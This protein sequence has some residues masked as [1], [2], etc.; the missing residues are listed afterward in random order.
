M[1]NE[2]A[3]LAELKTFLRMNETTNDT[4]LQDKLTAASRRVDRD[5]GRRF[6]VDGSATARTYRA[7]HATLLM[8]DDISTTNSLVV[9]VG[10]GSS[11]TTVDSTLFDTLPENALA[12]GWAIET[13]DRASGCWPLFGSTRVRVTAKWGWP[14]VPDPIKAACLLLAGRL[15][16]RKDSPEGVKGF[17][18]MGVVRV[19]R[20]DSDYDNAIGPYVRTVT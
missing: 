8:V 2:Y 9:E 20:Y 16:R 7:T 14:A 1:A 4:E 10:R 3:S 5:T 15:F 11:W 19:S 12:D 18:D 17:S 6:Y 13:F